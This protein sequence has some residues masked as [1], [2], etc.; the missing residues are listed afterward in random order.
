MAAGGIRAVQLYADIVA[1]ASKDSQYGFLAILSADASRR[2]LDGVSRIH[3]ER[4]GSFFQ[5]ALLDD[6]KPGKQAAALGAERPLFDIGN[7][8]LHKAIFG[9]RRNVLTEPAVQSYIKIAKIAYRR[10]LSHEPNDLVALHNLSIA[11]EF[12][13]K[14]LLLEGG[15]R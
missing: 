5:K 9:V 3:A 15:L 13:G 11:E 6:E 12:S 7:A 10:H 2:T 4:A 1:K 8:F 14:P